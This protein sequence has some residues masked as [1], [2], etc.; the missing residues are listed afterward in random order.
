MPAAPRVGHGGLRDA[1]PRLHPARELRRA[2]RPPR[3]VRRRHRQDP[4]P[5]GSRRHGRRTAAGGAARPAGG[6]LLGLQ[7]ALLLRAARAVRGGRDA[8]GRHRR[9]AGDGQ[10][11]ARRR[12]RG[13]ARRRLQPHRGRRAR[14][15]RRTATAASTTRPTTCS[16]TTAAATGTTRAPATCCTPRTPP[17]GRWS[18]TACGSGRARCTWTGSGSTS[19]RSSPGA[20]DG[21]IDLDDPP[22][23]SAID[24]DP[25]F[26]NLR[27]IA[28]AWDLAELPARAPVPGA[29]VVPVERPVPRRGAGV[30]ARRSRRRRQPDDAPLRQLRPVP[31]RRCSTP[32]TPSRA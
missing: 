25:D 21:S 29:R 7:P 32:I 1:R 31:G 4:V 14:S 13:R 17:C 8:R 5:R 20:S 26:R 23:I 2:R 3:H 11:A 16:R 30:R 10:G 27:L 6:Q 24:A 12:H 28:E 9:D 18:W 22:I 19:R 15:A